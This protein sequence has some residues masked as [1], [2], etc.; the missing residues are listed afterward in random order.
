MM[1]SNEIIADYYERYSEYHEVLGE[2]F[3]E[4]LVSKLAADLAKERSKTAYLERVQHVC[5][6]A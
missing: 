5:A 6:R 2:R 3:P 4:F 1:N